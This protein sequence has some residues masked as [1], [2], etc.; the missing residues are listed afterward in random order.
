MRGLIFH[1][2]LHREF[3]A[4]PENPVTISSNRDLYL[5][6]LDDQVI[7][8]QS[9]SHGKADDQFLQDSPPRPLII[10]VRQNSPFF[11]LSR[12]R[13][14]AGLMA[15]MNGGCRGSMRMRDREG[16][17]KPGLIVYA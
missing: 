14:T 4:I 13:L 6:R 5:G 15:R 12:I 10:I 9:L 7:G 8:Q 17:A 16:V 11:G 2:E 1:R 3:L